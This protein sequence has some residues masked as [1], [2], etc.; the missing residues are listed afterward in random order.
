MDNIAIEVKNV[1]KVYKLYDK[2][3]DRLKEALQVGHH[4][5]QRLGQVHHSQNNNRRSFSDVGRGAGK[6]THFRAF[7][8]GRRL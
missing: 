6:R 1:E 2:P 5:H 7:G 8:A 4:R 3:S